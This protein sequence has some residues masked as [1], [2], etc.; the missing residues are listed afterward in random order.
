M[1]SPVSLSSFL[2]TLLP[3]F[4]SLLTELCS[5]SFKFPTAS[6][7]SLKTRKNT[8]SPSPCIFILIP[9]FMLYNLGY[10]KEIS[11]LV[12]QHKGLWICLSEKSQNTVNKTEILKA[13]IIAGHTW[14][15]HSIA[16]LQSPCRENPRY[17]GSNKFQKN[18]LGRF[19]KFFHSAQNNN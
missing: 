3:L 1:I 8:F 18:V 10:L 11:F 15:C 6:L 2:F 13:K 16:C 7:I 19:C 9:C 4:L 14:L 5:F 17:F 12:G